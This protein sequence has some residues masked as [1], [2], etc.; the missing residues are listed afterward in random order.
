MRAQFR[1]SHR[2]IVSLVVQGQNDGIASSH[3]ISVESPQGEKSSALP[4][5]LR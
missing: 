3:Q 1:S 4:D 2:N 5:F